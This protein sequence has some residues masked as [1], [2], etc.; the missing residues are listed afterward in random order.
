M[1]ACLSKTNQPLFSLSNL[2]HQLD[3]AITLNPSQTYITPQI[4]ISAAVSRSSIASGMYASSRKVVYQARRLE[5]DKN[6]ENRKYF[7]QFLCRESGI[8]SS[9]EINKLRE[10]PLILSAGLFGITRFTCLLLYFVFRLFLK[11][12]LFLSPLSPLPSFHVSIVGY[13]LFA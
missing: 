2:V 6:V 12:F 10:F 13:F 3:W 9:L 7:R 1:P 11:S 8:Q 5:N 4:F